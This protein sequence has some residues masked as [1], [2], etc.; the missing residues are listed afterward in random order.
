[1][2]YRNEGGEFGDVTK[3]IGLDRTIVARGAGFGDLDN[4]GWLDLY[5]GT[6]SPEMSA[7]WPNVMFRNSAGREFQDVTQAGGFG[8]L[9][10]GQAIAFADWD[11]DG[12]QDVFLQVGGLYLD[13]GF[14]DVFF[15]N[16]GHSNRSIA[17][18]LEGRESNRFGVGARVRV[19][20]EEDARGTREVFAFV[21]VRSSSGCN[22]MRTSI[23]LGRAVRILELEVAWPGRSSQIFRDVPLD[24]F[25]RV[26]EGE[27]ELRVEVLPPMAH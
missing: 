15:R 26:R 7:L 5:L 8:H 10:K 24:S 9:Q 13:D 6:G 22:P 27:R 20:F 18:S 1:M 21:G 12:D 16:P 17:L 4:D 14:G 3:T 11:H 25:V 2:L 19:R 23:G